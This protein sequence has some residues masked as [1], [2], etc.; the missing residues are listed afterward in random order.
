MNR[1]D[2]LKSAALATVSAS[3]AT[4]QIDLEEIRVG[5][6]QKGFQSGR[7]T[8]KTLAEACL[9]RINAIDIRGP[10]IHSVIEINPDAL[11]IAAELD[12]E[13]RSKGPRG[14]LHGVPVLIKDNIDTGDAMN[15]TAGSLALLG[16]PAPRDAFLVTRLRDAG[17]VLLGKSNLSEWANFRGQRSTSG[18]SGRGG[19]TRN[20]YALDRNPSGS[21][22][23]SA[24]A[25]AAGL[26]VVAVGTETDGSVV[27]PASINGLVGIKPTVGLISRN[28]IIPVS[29]SQD[30]AGPMART[31][32]DAVLLL[33][34]LGAVDPADPVTSGAPKTRLDYTRFLDPGSLRG[35]RLGIV[36][37][38]FGFNAEV[39]KLI[40]QCIGVAK[41]HGAVIIDPVE[42]PPDARINEPE[43]EVLLYEFKSGLNTYLKLRGRSETL[44]SLIAFN[45]KNSTRELS[46]FGQELFEQ[47]EKKGPLTDAAYTRARAECIRL[48]RKE[49]IDA[50]CSKYRLQALVAPT[51]CLAWLTDN[52]NGDNAKGGCSTPPA[53]AG[54]PHITVPAGLVHGLPAGISFF[55]PAWSEPALIKVAY[56]F[57]QATKARRKPTFVQ[58][59]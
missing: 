46:L 17:A 33:N 3:A 29:A 34:A 9:A 39:D 22:S 42:I 14:P 15:T 57:E 18:W 51:S 37:K 58:S 50:V 31:V 16:S 52:V 59:V 27:S 54:Y 1:R 43:N 26:C 45:E 28:G 23:G 2:L 25:T 49:G 8:V 12:Q 7:F 20:P 47:A 13:R 11:K 53:V 4:P 30:T 36:R 10:A 48:T 56:A 6:I 21:S 41:S 38:S 5:D 55:G 19:Q 44:A 24:A 40:D 32:R 35:A